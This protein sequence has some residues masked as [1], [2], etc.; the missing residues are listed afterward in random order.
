[1]DKSFASIRVTTGV[2]IC[3]DDCDGKCNFPD[4]ND[5]SR[6][7]KTSGGSKKSGSGSVKIS[8]GSRSK[9][10]SGIGENLGDFLDEILGGGPRANLADQASRE[11]PRVFDL[12]R[13]KRILAKMNLRHL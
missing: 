3:E 4:V 1:M 13:A 10:A 2:E 9:S 6:R 8:G 5:R 12:A 11:C 7:S